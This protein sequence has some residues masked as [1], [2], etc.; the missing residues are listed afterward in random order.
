MAAS[1]FA[2]N[3][4]DII[5]LGIISMT[6]LRNTLLMNREGGKQKQTRSLKHE[7]VATVNKFMKKRKETILMVTQ[8]EQ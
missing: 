4:L 3:H 8:M 1:N 5:P 6:D 7:K 2:P